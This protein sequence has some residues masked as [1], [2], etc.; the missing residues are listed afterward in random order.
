MGTTIAAKLLGAAGG[1]HK[2]A[3]LPST[4]VQ[5]LGSKKRALGGMSTVAIVGNAGFIQYCD[6]VQNTPPNLRSK[7]TR[8]VAGKATL[9]A[10]CDTYTDKEGGS[11]GQRFKDEI[12]VS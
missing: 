8:L 11:I 5:I 12:E 4:V 3:S 1:L 9:A 6:I 7:V 2:L 10:R